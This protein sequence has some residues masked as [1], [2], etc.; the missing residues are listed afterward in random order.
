MYN[1]FDAMRFSDDRC[2]LCGVELTDQNRTVEHIFP[3]WLQRRF[4]L[5]NEVLTLPNGTNIRYRD[6]VIPCCQPCN[7]GPLSQLEG[8]IRNAVERGFDS[9]AALD[10]QRVFLWCS[11]LYYASLF[12]ELFLFASRAQPALG[13]L[14]TPERLRQYEMVHFFLQSVRTPMLLENFQPWSLLRFR[15]TPPE[16]PA[17]RFDYRDTRNILCL[18]VR[19]DEVGLVICL[20]DNGVHEEGFGDSYGDAKRAF[21]HMELLQRA[22][23]VFYQTSLFNRTPKYLIRLPRT[24]LE[25]VRVTP[26]PLRDLSKRPLHDRWDPHEYAGVLASLWGVAP[27]DVIRAAAKEP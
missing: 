15:M 8:E 5:W 21:R 16:S 13:T 24:H 7:G 27:E 14:M 1:P 11:K 25:P 6:H 9:F 17:L 3:G 20:Q 23:Q 19:M 2:F 12:K 26:L 10:P 4:N 18:A 22:A